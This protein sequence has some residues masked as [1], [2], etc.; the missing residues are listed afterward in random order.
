[1]PMQRYISDILDGK[2]G[3][4][5]KNF[6]MRWVACMVGDVHRILCRGGIFTYPAHT[7]KPEKPYKLRLLYECNPMAFICEQA[8]GTA[9]DGF[10]RILDIKPTELHQRVPFYCGSKQ[11]VAKAESFM[12]EFSLDEKPVYE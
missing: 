12:N 8:G 6:N 1:M 2:G 4:R 7:D 5:G 3:I 9:S 11:L 10:T